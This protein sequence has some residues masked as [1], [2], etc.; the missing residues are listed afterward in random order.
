MKP[1]PLFAAAFVAATVA[2]RWRRLSWQL[3]A[4]GVA[5]VIALCVWGSG[6]IQLPNLESIA[7][8]VGTAL[9]AYTYLVVGVLASTPRGRLRTAVARRQR[10]DRLWLAPAG[11]SAHR[12]S[13]SGT[14]KRTSDPGPG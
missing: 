1:G 11:A 3:R 8:D 14:S 10:P 13:P 5:A 2:V 12:G 7:Q 4:L 6:T 9:G